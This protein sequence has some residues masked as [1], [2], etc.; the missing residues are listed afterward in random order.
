M[1]DVTFHS[2]ALNSDMP[3]RAVLPVNLAAG[4][5]AVVYLLHGGGGNFRDWSNSSNVASFADRDLILI[6]P[7]GNSSYFA[8][9]LLS[10]HRTDTKT[11]S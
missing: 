2:T 6:M 9:Y 10:A 11:T 4:R 3:Y 7:E 8:N 5:T 1:R